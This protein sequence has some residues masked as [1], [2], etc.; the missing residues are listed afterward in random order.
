MSQKSIQVLARTFS[1]SEEQLTLEKNAYLAAH[2]HSGMNKNGKHKVRRKW[3]NIKQ[4]ELESTHSLTSVSSP[5]TPRPVYAANISPP[6][7]RTEMIVL[8]GDH[9]E[10]CLA[11][12][13][14]VCTRG[15]R[16][17]TPC[18]KPRKTH[19]RKLIFS[20]EETIDEKCKQ[21]EPNSCG[22]PCSAETLFR[23][24]CQTVSNSSDKCIQIKNSQRVIAALMRRRR[25]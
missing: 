7:L 22:C 12:S 10:T 19:K 18:E 14:T 5:P 23:R 13:E 11:A 20:I 24:H 8:P 2:S 6:R 4:Q 16:F 15:C 9:S 25:I 21:F 3:Y 1:V 17:R